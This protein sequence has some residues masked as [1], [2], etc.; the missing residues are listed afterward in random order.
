MAK[1]EYMIEQVR[2]GRTQSTIV[3]T[4]DKVSQEREVLRQEMRS[5]RR[6][7]SDTIRVSRL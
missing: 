1:N 5:D 7:S 6:A 2:N 4:A 3:T